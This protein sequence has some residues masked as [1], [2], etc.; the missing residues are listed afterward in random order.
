MDYE[1]AYEADDGD[2]SCISECD[3]ARNSFDNIN[4]S[5]NNDEQ[6][7]DESGFSLDHYSSLLES[8]KA[9]YLKEDPVSKSN[10]IYLELPGCMSY[11]ELP[12]CM[13]YLDV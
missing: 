6:D 12:G 2:V 7:T 3:E 8:V 13:S 11:L 1:T 4:E 5:Q 9:K 10:E